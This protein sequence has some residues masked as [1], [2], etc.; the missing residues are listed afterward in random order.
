VEAARSAD[1]GGGSGE[2]G[3]GGGREG[4]SEPKGIIEKELIF[5]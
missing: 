5:E 2:G 1:G 4:R 3:E